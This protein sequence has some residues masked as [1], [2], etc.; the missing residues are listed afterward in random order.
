[1]LSRGLVM[2]GSDF[3]RSWSR[4]AAPA[5]SAAT[6]EAVP[7]AR[8][9]IRA[10]AGGARARRSSGRE[11]GR[12]GARP[13][14]DRDVAGGRRHRAG[15][16]LSRRRRRG[17]AARSRCAR[18]VDARPPRRSCWCTTRRDRSSR[19]RL[20]DAVIEAH[21][22]AR[23]RDPRAADRGHGQGARA[24]GWI[25]SHRRARAARL[26]ADAARIPSGLAP[27]PRSSARGAKAW[28]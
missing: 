14:G 27:P 4:P 17:D 22:P 13:R 23:R 19:A 6:P 1:M 16:S 18:G 2:T 7:G 11:R 25:A 10:R 8:R 12:R 20:V 28:R 21:A 3:A 5:A 24:E 26:R 15:R 9:A